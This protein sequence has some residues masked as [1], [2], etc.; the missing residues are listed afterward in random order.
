MKRWC[1][2]IPSR[3]NNNWHPQEPKR[4]EPARTCCC[5]LLCTRLR[6]KYPDA[7]EGVQWHSDGL[8]LTF[9]YGV[10]QTPHFLW[11]YNDFPPQHPHAH[12]INI[13]RWY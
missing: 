6:G 11:K 13:S 1:N 3:D 8:Q 4:T 2:G 5:G 7:N 9:T 12:F 10:D